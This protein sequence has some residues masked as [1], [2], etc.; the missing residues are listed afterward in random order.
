MEH[1]DS[2]K[3]NGNYKAIGVIVK[4]TMGTV[5]VTEVI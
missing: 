5:G 3:E 4:K 2:G 1:W